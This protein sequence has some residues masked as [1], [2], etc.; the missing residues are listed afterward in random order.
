M[1]EI[2]TYI[3]RV[4]E[5]I[6]G[7]TYFGSP[8]QWTVKLNAQKLLRVQLHWTYQKYNHNE[9]GEELEE[10]H[11]G[12]HVIERVLSLAD[13]KTSGRATFLAMAGSMIKS[14]VC[15]QAR[16]GI[17]M[18]DGKKINSAY[19]IPASTGNTVTERASMQL[20]NLSAIPIPDS[21]WVQRVTDRYPEGNRISFPTSW[22]RTP[23]VYMHAENN[24]PSNPLQVQRRQHAVTDIRLERTVHGA[25][26]LGMNVRLARSIDNIN[27]QDL[28]ASVDVALDNYLN[29]LPSETPEG[30]YSNASNTF[31]EYYRQIHDE[32]SRHMSNATHPLVGEI[33]TQE[34]VRSALERATNNAERSL[35]GNTAFGI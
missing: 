21:G 27:M 6:Q 12:V 26:L 25:D 18:N 28:T 9:V 15:F 10:L 2:A 14:A 16:E 5:A 11:F 1:E 32:I 23:D 7:T 35:S 20:P 30:I 3:P 13:L 29:S 33:I 31:G 8:L 34:S 22:P 19:I 4:K 17:R 24:P